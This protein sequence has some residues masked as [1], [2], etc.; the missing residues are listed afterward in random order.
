MAA[1]VAMVIEVR[2]AL[3][4]GMLRKWKTGGASCS[5]QRRDGGLQGKVQWKA[6]EDSLQSGWL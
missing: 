4:D 6:P 5:F 3:S 2:C 1:G